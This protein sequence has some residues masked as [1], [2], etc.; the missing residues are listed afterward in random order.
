MLD[1]DVIDPLVQCLKEKFIP[2]AN[3]L[4]KKILNEAILPVT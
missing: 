4:K 1:E 2:N 3:G